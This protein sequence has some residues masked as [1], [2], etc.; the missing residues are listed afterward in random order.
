MARVTTADAQLT[1]MSRTAAAAR[2][3]AVA[4]ALV[5]FATAEVVLAAS[6]LV[7]IQPAYLH[8]ALDASGAARLLGVSPQDVH[9]LSDQTVRELL[10][11]PGTFAFS[12]PAGTAFYDPFEAAHMRDVRV[13]LYAF[14]GTSAVAAVGLV[15][16]LARAGD[17]RWVWIAVG[18][19]A[20]VLAASMTAAG[21]FALL[22]FDRAFE[23]F[24]R[25][26]FPGGNWAF[27]P[28]SQ[29]LVQL[30]PLSFWQLTSA[31]LG[32]LTIGGGL[33]VWWVARRRASRLPQA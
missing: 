2:P 25:V 30:Y 22:A 8:A 5:A 11:G 20:F 21:L 28:N 1:S 16:A 15:L 14:L 10:F 6:L 9:R 18:R 31:A 3:G 26:F 13:V 23:L 27:D 12:G 33:A 19:G 7:L 24:H 4:F 17:R 32:A 29:R